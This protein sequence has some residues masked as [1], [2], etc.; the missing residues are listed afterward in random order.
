MITSPS[1]F[2]VVVDG[3]VTTVVLDSLNPLT[4]YVVN[5]YSVV[6]EKSSEPL[7]GMET[8]CKSVS[9]SPLY[10][11]LPLFPLATKP[12]KDTSSSLPNGRSAQFPCSSGPFHK[13][14][15]AL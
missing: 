9:S 8:T 11:P 6:S 3:T 10:L 4:E 14:L 15:G 2:Q 1:L 13:T 12:S 5:V 7:T